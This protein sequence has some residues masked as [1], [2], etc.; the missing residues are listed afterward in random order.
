MQLALVGRYYERIGDHAVNIGERV[1]VHGHRLAARA[2][3]RLPRRRTRLMLTL[4]LA[5][6]A[7]VLATTLALVFVGQKRLARRLL[8]AGR[9]LSDD[10]VPRGTG[11]AEA[12]SVVERSV[13]R[14][15]LWGG[16]GSMAEARLAS[17]LAVIPQGRR[18]V[19][20]RRRASPTATRWPRATSPPATAMRSWR[21]RSPSS[22]RSPPA[23]QRRACPPRTVDLF[24]PPRRTLVLEADPAAEGRAPARRA[25]GHRRRHRPAPP[26]RRCAAT[27]WPTSATS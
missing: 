21:R 4:L 1:R 17:A 24:G 11:L 12:T 14:A 27:S 7:L 6:V 3:R 22:P 25:R 5:V 18:G 16:E 23:T 19:R 20:R 8:A 10:I 2:R 26:R 15:L 13:D 9:R